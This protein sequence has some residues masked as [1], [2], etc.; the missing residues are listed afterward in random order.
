MIA[1]LLSTLDK[2]VPKI[3]GFLAL[4]VNTNKRFYNDNLKFSIFFKATMP[5]CLNANNNYIYIYDSLALAVSINKYFYN[6][7]LKFSI[8]FKAIMPSCLNANFNI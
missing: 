6:H 7:N 5:S 3:L 4:A 2:L 1:S 8:F